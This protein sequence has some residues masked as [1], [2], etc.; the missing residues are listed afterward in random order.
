MAER[1]APLRRMLLA[2]VGAGAV[3]LLSGCGLFGDDSD[4]TSVFDA[5][6][7]MCFNA[8]AEVEAQIAELDEV[9]CA[10]PHDQEAYAVA[11]FQLPE[12]ESGDAF[13]G[14]ETLKAFADGACAQEFDDYVGVDYLDSELFFTYLL[15]SPRSWEQEDREVLCLVTGT[16]E[17]L[18]GS[19]EGTGR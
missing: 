3:L 9:P 8:P 18:E 16:G 5:E 6:P 10:D 15:P 7:G 2:T 11:E 19:V 14:D 17:K 13:P 4:Q 1:E 12:G